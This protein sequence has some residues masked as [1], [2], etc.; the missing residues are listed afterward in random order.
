VLRTRGR[1]RRRG[2]YREAGHGRQDSQATT[3]GE[4]AEA[5]DQAADQER[6]VASKDKQTRPTTPGRHFR[7][8]RLELPE[9]GALVLGSDGS[10]EQIDAA[11]ASTGRWASGDPGWAGHAIRFGLVAREKTVAPHGREDRQPR[12]VGS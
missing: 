10:I 11:G 7:R 12:S 1:S 5:G 4:E 2:T 3:Q 8:R 6:L 9:G